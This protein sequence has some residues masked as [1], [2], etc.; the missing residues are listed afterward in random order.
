MGSDAHV[1]IFVT[2]LKLEPE[3]K[4][5]VGCA[6]SLWQDVSAGQTL[7]ATQVATLLDIVRRSTDMMVRSYVI[8]A[9]TAQALRVDDG[10]VFDEIA[11]LGGDR[12]SVSLGA[13]VRVPIGPRA[14]AAWLAA[15]DGQDLA[16][17]Q[18]LANRLRNSLFAGTDISG[19]SARLVSLLAIAPRGAGS[20]RV[21]PSAAARECIF[22]ALT[23]DNPQRR[24]SDTSLGQRLD[25]AALERAAT[26]AL[27]PLLDAAIAKR[28]GPAGDARLVLIAVAAAKQRWSELDARSETHG[29]S[30][31]ARIVA[32]GL[33][34]ASHALTFSLQRPDVTDSHRA[35]VSEIAR[36]IAVLREHLRKS[37]RADVDKDLEG[38]AARIKLRL[39]SSPD[40]ATLVA[41]LLRAPEKK[42]R[43]IRAQLVERV[44]EDP[45]VGNLLP[46]LE[47]VLE[48]GARIAVAGL[49]LL[50]LRP[51]GDVE[52]MRA[53][54]AT[55]GKLGLS[56]TAAL[57][58]L[59]NS[60]QPNRAPYVALIAPLLEDADPD[61]RWWACYFLRMTAK[62]ENLELADWAEPILRRI[63]DSGRAPGSRETVAIEARRALQAALASTKRRDAFVGAAK[64]LLEKADAK[65]RTSLRKQLREALPEAID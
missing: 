1:E 5:A 56:I 6:R 45:E 11:K 21:A 4:Y 28:D 33:L 42:L 61:V 41:E 65:T 23:Q 25:R 40:A 12:F 32:H 34:M 19:A 63:V 60:S 47:D 50:A 53:H 3:G 58:T 31:D 16:I 20:K 39:E 51:S 64:T 22:A 2:E 8:R 57:S 29:K 36:R 10:A 15:T 43:N 9:L 55:R 48:P 18:E 30:A 13:D 49:H 62:E 37:D 52:A 7:T 17:Q 24:K 35:F 46:A 54:F 26:R 38:E 59:A 44:R 14:L 27:L